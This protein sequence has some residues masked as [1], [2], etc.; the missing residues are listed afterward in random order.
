MR[1]TPNDSIW[2]VF[3]HFGTELVCVAIVI[4]WLLWRWLHSVALRR[5]VRTANVSG[6]ALLFLRVFKPSKRSEGFTDRF[7]AYWR[8]AGPVWMIA[9]PDLA[10]A[11]MEP[12]E[13]FA[14][15]R[16]HLRKH[17]IADPGEFTTRV[18]GLDNARD[19]DG[20]FRINELYCTDDTWRPAVLRMIEKAGVVLLDLREYSKER[21][22]TR[23][24][25]TELLR[26]APLNKVILLIDANSDVSYLTDE[27]NSIWLQVA[28]FR[29]SHVGDAALRILRFG[30]G[31]NAE[32]HALFYAALQTAT[33]QDR[34][35]P[36][37][38]ALNLE[39]AV[40]ATQETSRIS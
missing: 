34:G 40:C 12:N 2:G 29:D 19:P 9:G 1:S 38:G 22:G 5:F 3:E 25:L 31:S 37:A 7:F 32:M 10:G 17:F 28:T 8:F 33:A 21:A 18:E 11:Y 14:Y 13:F 27:I 35:L 39:R 16:G 30:R 15:L 20:R 36:L 23:Y 26:R 24:E 6:S 4:L